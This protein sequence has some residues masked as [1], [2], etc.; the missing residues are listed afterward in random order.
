MNQIHPTVKVA[1]DLTEINE[2]YAHL[3]AQA[4]HKA[5]AKI[6]GHSLPGGEAMVAL[7]GVAQRDVNERRVELRE[8]AHMAHCMRLDHTRCWT[9]SGCM[10][11]PYAPRGSRA[12]SG[13][14][15]SR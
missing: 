14:P 5:A 13:S 4:I 15:A 6:D 2:L 8:E 11:G 7:A 12:V 9:G 1:R 3:L 10:P